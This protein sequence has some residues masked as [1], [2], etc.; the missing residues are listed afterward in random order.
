M[1]DAAPHTDPVEAPETAA[2][3]AT[4]ETTLTEGEAPITKQ[5][6]EI[7]GKQ[8][9]TEVTA[10]DGEQTTEAAVGPG[11]AATDDA[12]T[13]NGN[14]KD[15][16][17]KSTGGVPEHKVKK[18]NRKK[19]MPTLNLDCKP[20][21]YYWARLKGYPP[22]PSI[23]CSEDMIPE[24]LLA[25]RPVSAAR[26]DG[27]I[28]DDF[29]EGG[30]NVK[31]RTWP[32]MFLATN[33][34]VWLINSSL[35]PLDPEECHTKPQGKMTKALTEAYRIATEK[36]ELDYFKKILRDFDEETA[37]IAAEYAQKEEEAAARAAE[38]AEK[39]GEE[40][41]EAEGKE[42]KKKAPR[43]SKGGDDEDVEMEDADVTKSTKKRKK[44]A[45]SDGEVK[46][47]KTPKVT[48]INAPKTPNGEAAST[49]KASTAKPKKKVTA[50]K[51]EEAVEEKKELTESERLEQREKAI[52]YLRHRLQKGFLARD[53]APKEEEMSGMADFFSQLEKYDNLEP[54]IIRTTKIHKVLKAVVKLTFIPKEEDY[55]FKTRSAQ[56]L[57]TWNK[58]MEADGGESGGKAAAAAAEE[59]APATN[60][61]STAAAAA[62]EESKE[63]EEKVVEKAET[64]A[65]EVEK[66]VEEAATEE[67]K[68]AEPAAVPEAT[69]EKGDG[70][71]K[72]LDA[73]VD[74]DAKTTEA[75]AKTATEA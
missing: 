58:R 53:A 31:E 12:P 14:S 7:A 45:E 52:L 54:S 36:H 11:D 22:W 1:S 8:A 40:N 32:I 28:R 16:K 26:P 27:S 50:P 66:K 4:A 51:E 55:N 15:K 70:G 17:R 62:T 49:K 63:S 35:K 30:K 5:D 71:D 67:P 21:D 10:P 68:T 61:D 39:E 59:K 23:I 13:T 41:V 57:E 44:D 56:L 72:V 25:S 9:T 38:K 69:A 19:S 33:E 42:K 60:G 3:P 65:D 48:K 64:A 18:L 74:G 24:P 34:F 43:K 47:K 29:K 75:P 6:E 37:R 73:V 2:A 46:A 20:G